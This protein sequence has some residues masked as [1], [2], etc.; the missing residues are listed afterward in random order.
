MAL[1]IKI[2]PTLLL[3]PYA[4][5][6]LDIL[7]RSTSKELGAFKSALA[8]C[9]H[10]GL[11]QS[12]ISRMMTTLKAKSLVQLKATIRDIDLRWWDSSFDYP[13][14]KRHL[15]SF[16]DCAEYYSVDTKITQQKIKDIAGVLFGPTRS[17]KNLGLIKDNLDVY[18]CEE[19]H[20]V[21]LKRKMG[22]IPPAG[23]LSSVQIGVSRKSFK[24]EAIITLA[25][26]PSS[27][28]WINSTF[29]RLNIFHVLFDLSFIDERCRM[30][31]NEL[32]KRLMLE[33]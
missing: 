14:V 11:V 15:L 26:G 24:K 13:P 4:F 31:R 17:I 21:A 7:F 28:I 22:A 20:L 25:K 29:D 12:R 10:Y 19:D 8:F 9:E 33:D 32:I 23:I 2:S 5:Q 27:L 1:N 3:S 18:W 16:S 6:I 30:A